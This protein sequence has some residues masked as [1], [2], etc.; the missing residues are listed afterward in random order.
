MDAH[1]ICLIGGITLDCVLAFYL[2][3]NIFSSL[4][5]VVLV[6]PVVRIRCVVPV[7]PIVGASSPEITTLGASSL[8][9]G[10][11]ALGLLI[12]MVTFWVHLLNLTRI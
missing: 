3:W 5:Q 2:L 11:L 6:D 9:D 1:T 12:S 10:L 7:D 4:L 8:S